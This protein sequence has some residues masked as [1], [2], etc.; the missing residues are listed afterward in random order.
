MT[1]K[2]VTVLSVQFTNNYISEYEIDE[3]SPAIKVVRDSIQIVEK[4]IQKVT[5]AKD[6]DAKAIE[7]LDKNQQ[8]FGANSG[9]NVTELMKMVDYYKVKRTDLRNSYDTLE[10]KLT[11]LNLLLANLNNKLEINTQKEGICRR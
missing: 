10:Q 9:L 5:N 8:V 2:S 3:K 11:K 7:L 4:E 6:S 1:P